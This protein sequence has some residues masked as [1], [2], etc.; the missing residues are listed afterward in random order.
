MAK[1][2]LSPIVHVLALLTGFIGP[3]IVLFVVKEK[4]VKN[5][6]K[7]SLN[8][9]FSVLIY[10]IVA[11]VLTIVLIGLLL[12]PILFVLNISPTKRCY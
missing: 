8:W 2:A 5:N 12:F 1:N 11:S 4:D 6:A 10:F 7:L 9:Q 3:L